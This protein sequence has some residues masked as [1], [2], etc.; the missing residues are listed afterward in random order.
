MSNTLS[1][2]SIKLFPQTYNH[3]PNGNMLFFPLFIQHIPLL[4]L[5][6]P[7]VSFLKTASIFIPIHNCFCQYHFPVSLI[8]KYFTSFILQYI[9]LISHRVILNILYLTLVLL[10]KFTNILFF[11]TFALIYFSGLYYAIIPLLCLASGDWILY[12]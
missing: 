4:N 12:C 2:H 1:D 3:A 10:H 5:F 9:G 8:I 7:C 11:S 6:N